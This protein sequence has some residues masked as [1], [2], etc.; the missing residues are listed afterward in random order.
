MGSR[1]DNAALLSAA[2]VQMVI[3]THGAHNLA[4]LRQEAGNAVAH[5]L[6]WDVALAALTSAPADA[7]G[8]ERDYGM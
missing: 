8:R 3:T 7:F 1:Y 6:P 2:G 5:G 4:D